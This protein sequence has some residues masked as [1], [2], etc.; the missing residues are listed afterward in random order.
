MAIL[1]LNLH[2]FFFKFS[3]WQG[4]V[5]CSDSSPKLKLRC[6]PTVL[7]TVQIIFQAHFCP[8]K[9]IFLVIAGWKFL[10]LARYWPWPS[11][12]VFL[13][14]S[15]RFLHHGSPLTQR[16]RTFPSHFSFLWIP[17][18]PP[19]KTFCLY[20]GHVIRLY[21]PPKSP[22]LKVNRLVML[23]YGNPYSYVT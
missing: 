2:F 12:P 14:A 17:S 8:W 22:Y 1:V 19:K 21:Q 4:W 9:N 10:F 5:F 11:M 23:I 13:E 20:R 7:W 3:L 16:W 6:W 18:L 15:L